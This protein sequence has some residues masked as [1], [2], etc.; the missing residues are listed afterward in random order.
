MNPNSGAIATFETKGDAKKAGHTVELSKE[1]AL[2][3]GPMNRK[4]RRA[5]AAQQRRKK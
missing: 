3:L 2:E 5:W 4:Q 1:E